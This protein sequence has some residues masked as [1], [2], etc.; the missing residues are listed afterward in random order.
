MDHASTLSWVSAEVVQKRLQDVRTQGDDLRTF[1]NEFV[2]SLIENV[3][4]ITL[5]FQIL[6]QITFS[7]NIRLQ[8]AVFPW[9][10]LDKL[11]FLPSKADTDK[12][13]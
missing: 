8:V 12:A 10:D 4:P 5:R 7:V 9:P 13:H 6:P 1:L 11:T 3:F 2:A